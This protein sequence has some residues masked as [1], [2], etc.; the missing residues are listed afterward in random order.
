MFN[1][2][3]QG[4]QVNIIHTSSAMPTVEN[5]IVECIPNM[6]LLGYY[7]NMPTFPMDVTIK[8]GDKSLPYKGLNPN[9]S[10]AKATNPTT[11]EEVIIA[12]DKDALN[13]ALRNLKQASIDHINSNP[14]HE[15]RIKS[16]D[17]LITQLNPE[18]LEKA[19][20]EQEMAEMR[21]QMAQMA[22]TI[23]SLNA[24]LTDDTS[25]FGNKKE[26]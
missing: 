21:K 23:A 11:M 10:I 7:P 12:C 9:A 17:V 14:F 22:Q 15:Q 16:I 25:S 4:S 6:P 19:Q 18:Q 20:R 5:G 8:I 24:K 1:Q 3:R 2:L 26:N 13:E